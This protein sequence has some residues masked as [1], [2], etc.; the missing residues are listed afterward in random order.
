MKLQFTVQYPTLQFP[1]VL[2]T[3]PACGDALFENL[4]QCC[5]LQPSH[6]SMRPRAPLGRVVPCAVTKRRVDSIVLLFSPFLKVH[7]GTLHGPGGLALLGNTET[8]GL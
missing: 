5:H 4:A 3:G 8:I 1:I 6:C 2:C 7:L